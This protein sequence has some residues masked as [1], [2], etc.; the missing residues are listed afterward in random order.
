MSIIKQLKDAQGNNIVPIASTSATYNSEGKSVDALIE[1]IN[2]RFDIV[3]DDIEYAVARELNHTVQT[4]KQVLQ[5]DQK[6][7]VRE[8]IG[9]GDGKLDTTPTENSNRLVNSGN[10][11]KAINNIKVNSK[12][13]QNI[14]ISSE[15]NKPYY[16]LD[17]GYVPMLHPDISTQPSL[18]SQKFGTLDMYEIASRVEIDSVVSIENIDSPNLTTYLKIDLTSIPV[19]YVYSTIPVEDLTYQ[20]VQEIAKHPIYPEWIMR[21]LSDT[22]TI[23]NDL[24]ERIKIIYDNDL[25]VNCLIK[26]VAGRWHYLDTTVGNQLWVS[27]SQYGNMYYLS[28]DNLKRNYDFTDILYMGNLFQIQP[29]AG[30]GLGALGKIDPERVKF[31]LKDIPNKSVILSANAFNDTNQSSVSTLKSN[32]KLLAI[33][34]SFIPDFVLCKYYLNGKDD[35]YYSS[36]AGGGGAE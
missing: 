36:N 25:H 20:D 29:I 22:P 2:D 17:R 21:H 31:R 5:E 13:E 8:N 6:I 26:N 1:E 23:D 10:I 19:E 32:R 3:G 33:N 15:D 12:L 16:K 28:S 18:L 9:F 35:Y 34:I 4:T 7:Q 27:G 30:K 24:F 14:T 11:Y